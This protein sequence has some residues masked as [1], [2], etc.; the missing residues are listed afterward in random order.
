MKFDFRSESVKRKFSSNLF[1][2]NLIMRCSKKNMG[3]FPFRLLKKEIKKPRL[4]FK[5][6]SALIGIRNNWALLS[7]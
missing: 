2:C 4:K 1:A 5:P 7:N 3:T 6:G